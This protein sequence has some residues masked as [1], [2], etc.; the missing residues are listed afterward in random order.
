MTIERTKNEIIVRLSP[1]VD[2]V[3][4]Q[5]MLDFLK[6][7]ELTANTNANQKDVDEL[8]KIANKSMM[9][10]ISLRQQIK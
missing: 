1:K 8:S 3:D 6:Y 9:S 10:K 5:N 2:L 7:K 4:L